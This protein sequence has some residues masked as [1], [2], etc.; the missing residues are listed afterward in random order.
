MGNLVNDYLAAWST[1]HLGSDVS[2]VPPPIS[3]F[4]VILPQGQTK[5]HRCPALTFNDLQ[6]PQNK[7]QGP[8]PEPPS[9]SSTRI[10]ALF[11]WCR[12][13]FSPFPQPEGLPSLRY[14][15]LQFHGSRGLCTTPGTASYPGRSSQKGTRHGHSPPPPCKLFP[16]DQ[17][18]FAQLTLHPHRWN[19]E[20]N[21][22]LEVDRTAS[23]WPRH[24][25]PWTSS[26][27]AEKGLGGPGKK[28]T[29]S[30]RAHACAT[31]RTV[32]RSR[33]EG[34]PGDAT[35]PGS[36]L[37]SPL[38]RDYC[39]DGDDDEIT[40]K[41]R[42]LDPMATYH[43]KANPTARRPAAQQAQ[44]NQ[45]VHSNPPYA[46]SPGPPQVIAPADRLPKPCASLEHGRSFRSKTGRCK[47]GGS[48]LRG[49]ECLL[50]QLSN[51]SSLTAT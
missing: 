41:A 9:P 27:L 1:W 44:T 4:G 47:V 31:P 32:G 11:Q 43:Y 50:T 8:P 28:A 26:Q 29:E 42:V 7:I 35:L 3:P 33:A 37:D 46:G 17:G 49:P 40:I 2:E 38:C 10:T 21:I 13:L 51:S 45:P 23:T 30:M 39:D 14:R 19:N 34:C 24:P 18:C 6:C 12:P 48:Q 36:P 5:T 16:R 20:L 15:G 25:G 22:S